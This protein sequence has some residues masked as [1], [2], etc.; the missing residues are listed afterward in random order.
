AGVQPVHAGGRGVFPGRHR[1]DGG[2]GRLRRGRPRLHR[3]P[4]AHERRQL[5][6]AHARFD[7]PPRTRR[8]PQGRGEVNSPVMARGASRVTPTMPETDVDGTVSPV[9]GASLGRFV[10]LGSLGAGGMGV[11]LSAY[12]PHLDRRVALKLIRGER[13]DPMRAAILREAQAMARVR[14]P[15]LVTRH[16]VGFIDEWGYVIME[17]VAGRTLRDWLAEKDRPWREVL[18]VLV[19]AGAGLAA[20]HAAGI[21]HRDFKPEN[22]L[23]GDDGRARVSDFGLAVAG[24]A[25][26]AR[27]GTPAYMAPEQ[28]GG[29]TVDARADQYA[30]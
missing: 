20:A 18:D 24:P 3:D 16:E 19:P 1:P 29:E 28:L 9:R 14:H 4:P 26:D 22:V 27:G 6:A 25:K 17:E 21:V 7:P 11:V 5:A 2:G 10:V 12:D 8:D 15:N 23:L 13:E 30:F